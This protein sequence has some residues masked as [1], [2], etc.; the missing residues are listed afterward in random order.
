M[1]T[2]FLSR[3]ANAS[4]LA[5]AQ[6]AASH[7][8]FKRTPMRVIALVAVALSQAPAFDR[9]SATAFDAAFQAAADEALLSFDAKSSFV[10]GFPSSCSGSPPGWWNTANGLT[11][12]ALKDLRR[13]DSANKPLLRAA[14]G[15]HVGD[16]PSLRPT[17]NLFNDDQLWWLLLATEMAHLD[18]ADARWLGAARA[19]WAEVVQCVTHDCGTAVTWQRQ[20]G[21]SGGCVPTTAA[22]NGG[23][24]ASIANSLLMLVSAKLHEL[25][26]EASYLAMAD[27]LWGWLQSAVLDASTGL[28]HDGV[29][30][31]SACK[32]RTGFWSYNVGVPVAALATLYGSTRNATYLEAGAALAQAGMRYFA[33]SGG[34]CRETACE[35]KGSCGCDGNEFRGPF[36][37]GLSSL[38]Q[39]NRDAA[40]GSFIN[41]TLTSALAHDCN[42][43]WQFQEHWAGPYDMQAT[44]DTQLPV[45]DL[46]ASAYVV[47]FP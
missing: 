6:V 41:R 10:F 40:I 25:T 37:R 8:A 33:D 28:V 44:T 29:E 21:P 27:G 45:L 30:Q 13:G 20:A 3:A 24:K 22:S 39:W 32:L 12:L 42:A 18:G 1:D 35:G 9:T 15:K 46:F 31:G 4:A 17:Q 2:L 47:A 7:A 26:G 34:V 11:A 16:C 5:S 14:L 23:Y 38:F 36:E 43:R 19:G